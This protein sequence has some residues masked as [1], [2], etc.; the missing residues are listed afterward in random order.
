LPTTYELRYL[1][2][3]LRD[4]E[5]IIRY[6]ITHVGIQSARAVRQ[7]IET[8]LQNLTDYPLMGS[9][10]PDPILAAQGYRKLVLTNTY[11]AI[12]KVLDSTVLIYRIVNGK[13]DYPRLLY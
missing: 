12:Y 7:R 13:T 1:S 6:H 9:T 5:E 8:A 3:A 10:H 11:V 2:P 4:F